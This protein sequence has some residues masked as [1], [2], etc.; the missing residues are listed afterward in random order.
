M[1]GEPEFCGSTARFSGLGTCVEPR[2]CLPIEVIDAI[3][4]V[5]A[6][7][8]LVDLDEQLEIESSLPHG[9]VNAVLGVLRGLDRPRAAALAGALPRAGLGVGEDIRFDL[10]LIARYGCTVHAMDPVPRAAEYAHS[11]AAGEP[12]FIFH[13]LALWSR[14]ET[15]TFHP[16][17]K[18]G[19]VSHSAI[20]CSAPPRHSTPMDGHW[21]CR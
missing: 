7:W 14:D 17:R 12:R 19:Y 10:A 2:D 8:V 18:A 21:G 6:G 11:A 16:P 13:Q 9:H 5:L 3:R 1:P 15:L 4:K 20:T